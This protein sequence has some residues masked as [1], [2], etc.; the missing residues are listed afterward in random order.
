[1]VDYTEAEFDVFYGRLLDRGA[2]I[3]AAD[4]LFVRALR[5]ILE[6]ALDKEFEAHIDFCVT[7]DEGD[8]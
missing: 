4:E 1:M 2:H 7:Q 3:Y 8:R 6:H 5:F